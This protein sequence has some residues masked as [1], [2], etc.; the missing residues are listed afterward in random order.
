[1]SRSWQLFLRDM[2]E[3]AQ[4]V[5]RYTAGRPRPLSRMR[6]PTTPLCAI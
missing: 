5:T 1:M 4:K 2:L 3:A 6:W